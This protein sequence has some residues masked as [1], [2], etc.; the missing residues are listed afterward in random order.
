MLKDLHKNFYY[1][2]KKF[3]FTY[4]ATKYF[5]KVICTRD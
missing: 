2:K 5:N 1:F 4:L 3:A